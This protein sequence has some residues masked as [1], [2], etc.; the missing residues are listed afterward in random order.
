MCVCV[1]VISIYEV[2]GLLLIYN[3]DAKPGFKQGEREQLQY[4]LWDIYTQSWL[5]KKCREGGETEKTG[6]KIVHHWT[7]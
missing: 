7:K 3:K 1:C 2:A 6:K 4:I 5:I